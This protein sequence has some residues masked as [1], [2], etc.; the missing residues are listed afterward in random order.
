MNRS[1]RLLNSACFLAAL[2][3]ACSSTPD[4]DDQTGS[5]GTTGAGGDVGAGGTAAGGTTNS[6]GS[7]TGGNATGGATSGGAATGGNT[8]SGGAD[9][10]G[11]GPATGGDGNGGEGTGGDGSGGGDGVTLVEPIERDG[12]YVFEFGSVLFK[13]APE[14]GARITEFSYAGEDVLSSVDASNWGSTFWTSPQAEWTTSWPPEEIINDSTYTASLDGTTVTLTNQPSTLGGTT[15]TIT[16]VITPN[17]VVGAIDIV[18]TITNAGTAAVSVAPWEISRVEPGGLTYY[19]LGDEGPLA[20]PGNNDL[21]TVTEG[22]INWFDESAQ[23]YDAGT[24]SGNHKIHADGAE[25]W[26]AHATSGGIIFLKTFSDIAS[27][28]TAPD[29]GEIE[30]YSS[31]TYVEVENQGAYVSLAGGESLSY[32]VRWALTPATAAVAVGAALGDETRA[33]ATTVGAP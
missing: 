2:S 30:L 15:I 17:L 29:H 26:L 20:S 14:D 25:G 9:S 7:A 24:N 12:A 19:P 1:L 11:G 32:A 16:K 22:G 31:G 33:F 21:T 23:I 5:G 27:S 10:A 4:P 18:Y 6:G 3:V 28:T 8:A 13:I